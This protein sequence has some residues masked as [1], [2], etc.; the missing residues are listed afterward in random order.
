MPQIPRP[1]QFE[2]FE[3]VPTPVFPDITQSPAL[4][5]LQPELPPQPILPSVPRPPVFDLVQ[6]E[7]PPQPVLLDV[8]RPPELEFETELPPRPT[9]SNIPHPPVLEH[10][11]PEQPPKPFI[12]EVPQ[13]PKPFIPKVPQPPKYELDSPSQP[14]SLEP[15]FPP[16]QFVPEVPQP[17]QLEP[18]LPPHP[19]IPEFPRPPQF[20]P[21]LPPKPSLPDVPVH[22]QFLEP[23]LPPKSIFP[24]V[25]LPPQFEFFEPELPPQSFLPDFPQA[26]IIEIFESPM[27]DSPSVIIYE[28]PQVPLIEPVIPEI[29]NANF[30]DIPPFISPHQP[31]II[32]PELPQYYE[33][34]YPASPFNPETMHYIQEF[35][36]LIYDKAGLVVDRDYVQPPMVNEY[37]DICND[38]C[39]LKRN[40]SECEMCLK[41]G[42]PADYLELCSNC[43]VSPSEPDCEL[44]YPILLNL[45]RE[46]CIFE[47][48]EPDC[49]ICYP[50]PKPLIQLP[51]T[52]NEEPIFATVIEYVPPQEVCPEYCVLTPTSAECAGCVLGVEIVE[53][54][55]I[56]ICSGYCLENPDDVQCSVCYATTYGNFVEYNEAT[57]E[58]LPT[59][60]VINYQCCYGEYCTPMPRNGVCPVVCKDLCTTACS[61]ECFNPTC[62][63]CQEV[64]A[65]NE[66]R[67]NQFMI[68]LKSKLSDMKSRYMAMI[69]ACIRRTELMYERE[70]QAIEVEVD[71]SFLLA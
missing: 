32:I 22:P 24:N 19:I 70:L 42:V 58:E 59:L 69:E 41:T 20:E 12:P 33:P 71:T 57:F 23:E 52:L 30:E 36:P 3:P 25:P 55:C 16:K 68:W 40:I 34:S 18:A 13:P 8:P 31:N 7:L 45:C 17:P 29:I 9:I 4:E 14:I 1:P 60:E 54:V 6:P 51:E 21:K 10:L 56:D 50:Q 27:D 46:F 39:L 43:L 15:E 35:S 37:Q 62:P 5:F 49:S 44:C 66:H 67:R 48:N 26:P 61:N 28:P 38:Y 2:I 63:D 11:Q 47:E 64:V 65:L 53:K